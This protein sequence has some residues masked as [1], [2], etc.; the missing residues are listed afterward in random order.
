MVPLTVKF[1][2]ILLVF[3]FNLN[4][5]ATNEYSSR[6][7]PCVVIRPSRAGSGRVGP[8]RAGVAQSV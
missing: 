6:D 3:K 2:S 5:K 7:I 8:G 4:T 1:F